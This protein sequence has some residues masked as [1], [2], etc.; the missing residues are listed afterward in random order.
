MSRL[1]LASS[2]TERVL[3]VRDE[4]DLL[5]LHSSCEEGQDGHDCGIGFFDRQEACAPASSSHQGP[6]VFQEGRAEN[7]RRAH[8]RA[9]DPQ[10]GQDVYE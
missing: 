6:A 3:E 5:F 10:G 1:L 4:A 8:P 2:L 7:R 9:R